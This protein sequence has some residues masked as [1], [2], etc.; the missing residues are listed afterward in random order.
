MIFMKA[1]NIK[2]LERVYNNRYPSCLDCD[3]VD[4]C[5]FVRTSEYDCYAIKP[6]CAD[7]L[8]SRRFAICP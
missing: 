8:W 2:I 5:D 3:L 1:M 7:C 4:G 6:S